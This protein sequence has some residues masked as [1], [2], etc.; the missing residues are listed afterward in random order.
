MSAEHKAWREQRELGDNFFIAL[1]HAAEFLTIERPK[2]IGSRTKAGD[3]GRDG[4][5]V[6]ISVAKDSTLLLKQANSPRRV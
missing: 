4:A 3:W 6:G 5:N 2:Y 1:T